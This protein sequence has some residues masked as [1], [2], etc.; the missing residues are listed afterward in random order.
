MTYLNVSVTLPDGTEVGSFVI[1]KG[2]GEWNAESADEMGMLIGEIESLWNTYSL[3]DED[4]CP[5]CGA[6]DSVN[7][8]ECDE[9]EHE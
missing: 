9:A 3:D 7:F 4:E 2:E 5:V 8:H 1:G 6:L